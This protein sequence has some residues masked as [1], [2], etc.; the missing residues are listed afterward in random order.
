MPYSL[1][2]FG[3]LE[4]HKLIKS[5]NKIDHVAVLDLPFGQDIKIYQY[6]QTVHGKMIVHGFLPRL[7]RFNRTFGENIELMRMLKN[8]ALIPREPL[9]RSLA[10]SAQDVMR[11]FK[12]RYIVL[13]KHYFAP[14]AFNRVNALVK[15]TLPTRLIA[16][17]EH[18]SAYRV[19]D[20]GGDA[21][22]GGLASRIDFGAASRFPVLLEGWSQG[23]SGHGRTFA[24]SNA[25]VSTLWCYLPK[26]TMMKM[27][28]RLAPLNF[29]LLPKQFVKIL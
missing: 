20:E 15:A 7:P 27:E 14:D 12:V 1:S 17:D 16:Q 25:Q 28:L 5:L 18:I 11:L 3:Q 13:H 21:R 2:L 6:Y 29:T 10:E 22:E 9:D 4:F 23:E 19:E 26:V 24:W 8:P